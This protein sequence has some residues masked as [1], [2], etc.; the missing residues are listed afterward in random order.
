MPLID[1]C[2]AFLQF[3]TTRKFCLE[4]QLKQ[5]LK[6]LLSRLSFQDYCLQCYEHIIR[7]S[8]REHKRLDHTK[9]LVKETKTSSDLLLASSLR[10]K[11]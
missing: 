9:E 10:D 3:I 4:N 7:H 1:Y 8:L 6:R 2:K 5:L 11:A